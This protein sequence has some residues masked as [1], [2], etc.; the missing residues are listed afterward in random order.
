TD[1]R[2]KPI[3][4]NRDQYE[5]EA[6]T[7]NAD[8]TPKVTERFSGIGNFET[9]LPFFVLAGI[10]GSAFFTLTLFSKGKK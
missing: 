9:I 2:G 5:A 3:N 4:L 7:M 1:S 8:G 10:L 6:K